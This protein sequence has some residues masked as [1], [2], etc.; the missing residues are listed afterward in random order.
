ML[1]THDI[2]IVRYLDSEHPPY[3]STFNN[4]VCVVICN[5]LYYALVN[6]GLTGRHLAQ[7]RSLVFVALHTT[8]TRERLVFVTD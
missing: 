6:T 7:G 4:D 3:I 2:S 5:T 1:S 8:K